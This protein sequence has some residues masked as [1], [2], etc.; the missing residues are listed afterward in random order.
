M[1]YFTFT[2][3]SKVVDN[4]VVHQIVATEYVGGHGGI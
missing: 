1:S 3:E 2:G 4:V